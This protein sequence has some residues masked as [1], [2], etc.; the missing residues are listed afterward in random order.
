METM[1]TR[2]YLAF[3][4][5]L[6]P[7]SGFQSAQLREMEILMG[8][9]DTERIAFSADA[10]YLDALKLPDGTPSSSWHKVKARL[11]DPP[12]MRDA[13]RAWLYRT[14]IEGSTPDDEGD[15]QVVAKFIDDYVEALRGELNQ[16]SEM[17]QQQAKH[18]EDRERLRKRY[19]AEADDAHA[20]LTAQ[21]EPENERAEISRIRAAL[22]FIESYRELPLLAWPREVLDGVVA[23]EQAFLIFRQRHARMVER[24]I[25]RRTGTGGSAGVDYL[26][27]TALRY[28]VF[29]D[30]WAVRTLLLRRNALPPLANRAFY[31][32]AGGH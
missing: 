21:A 11:E 26:D 18:D 12:S 16:T 20:F 23:L 7:A 9:G 1:T 2:D 19:Q 27:S 5:K 10:S 17:A 30:V 29:K 13:M 25:G 15:E 8:L 31:D 24:I 22:V 28:R 3:R 6:Y 32:F 14:P 4:D